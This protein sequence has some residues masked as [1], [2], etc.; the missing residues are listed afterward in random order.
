MQP[1]SLI[2]FSQKSDTRFYSEPVECSPDPFILF[3]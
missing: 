3:P 1:E 2:L